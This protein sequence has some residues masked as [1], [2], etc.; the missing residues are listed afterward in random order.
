[1]TEPL[2]FFTFQKHSIFMPLR[3]VYP[4]CM[5]LIEQQPQLSPLHCL[6]NNMCPVNKGCMDILAKRVNYLFTNVVPDGK[7]LI[8]YFKYRDRPDSTR[9]GIFHRDMREPM[10]MTLNRSAL[11]KFQRE[12][13]VFRWLPT[14]DYLLLGPDAK[15]LPVESLIKK[16]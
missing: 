15:L 11:A 10:L 16:P 1:M 14:Q 13:I 9:A 7:L 3:N 12:G 2:T 5:V 6:K 4:E 8:A